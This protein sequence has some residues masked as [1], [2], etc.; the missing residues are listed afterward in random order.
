MKPGRSVR[1]QSDPEVHA[2]AGIVTA[3]DFVQMPEQDVLRLLHKPGHATWCELQGR[4]RILLDL[5]AKQRY[6]SMMKGHT[7]SPPSS[8]RDFVFAEAI[9]N[10]EAALAKLR[11]HGHLAREVG[12]CLRQK[13]YT[14]QSGGVPL[15]AP[16]SHDCE[17]IPGGNPGAA[18][19]DFPYAGCAAGKARTALSRRDDRAAF[20]DSKV[21]T[22]DSW[23]MSAPVNLDLY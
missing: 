9:R 22:G 18:A 21:D 12:L 8:S 15:P 13:D 19:E 6:A 4:R 11:R 14:Q 16:T 17:V 5:N 2:R 20:G 10:T 23:N 7:F 1:V 3:Y